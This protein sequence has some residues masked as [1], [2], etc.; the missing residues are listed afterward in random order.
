[1]RGARIHRHQIT[2]ARSA[3]LHLHST[4][5]VTTEGVPLGVLGARCEAPQARAEHDD[6]L[7]VA[8]PIEEKKS[9]SW[10]QGPRECEQT[11]ANELPDTR[12][13]CVM[14]READFFELFDEQRQRHK[15]DLLVR[16]MHARITADKLNLFDC[17][18]SGSV[19][20]RLVIPVP[21]QSARPKKS[22]QKERAGH[23]QRAAQ[24]QLRYREVEFPR[25]SITRAKRRSGCGWCMFAKSAS[26]GITTVY[27]TTESK[28][29]TRAIASFCGRCLEGHDGPGG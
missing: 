19:K 4:L 5:A 14:D 9:F 24:V 12:L 7:S 11:A 13:V 22:K 2:G 6:R 3:G 26:A 8:I 23:A 25:Q 28:R 10:I 1:M 20:S 17:V 16:A 18:R 29:R 27:V 15:V 21:R